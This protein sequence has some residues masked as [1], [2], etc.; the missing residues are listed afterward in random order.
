MLLLS[1]VFVKSIQSQQNS[2]IYPYLAVHFNPTKLL[3]NVFTSFRR[4]GKKGSTNF[5]ARY[6]YGNKQSKGIKNIHVNIRSL[7][8]RIQEVK[9]IANAYSPHIL[10]ISEAELK[11]ENVDLTKLKI[12][13]YDFILPK[14]WYSAGIARVVVY[15]KK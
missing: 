8:N 2:S 10:G 3:T 14:S 1:G 9:N 15:V 13:G 5:L 4:V 7:K 12:P 11:K 6:K